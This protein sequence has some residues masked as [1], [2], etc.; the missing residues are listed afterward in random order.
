MKK[1]T[2]ILLI[3]ALVY[4]FPL[5]FNVVINN[6]L[7][8]PIHILLWVAF[9]FFVVFQMKGNTLKEKFM[10]LFKEVKKNNGRR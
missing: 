3:I 1:H 9:A 4:F 10:S 7:G 2:I 6:A 8:Y 5:D